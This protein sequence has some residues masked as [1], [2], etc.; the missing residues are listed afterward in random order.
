MGQPRPERG[1]SVRRSTAG[2]SRR[3]AILPVPLRRENGQ[4]ISPAR[5][6]RSNTPPAD[7]RGAPENAARR[8]RP[9]SHQECVG[10]ARPNGRRFG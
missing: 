1:V 3:V 7:R 5:H 8:E 9:Q 10:Q 2:L 4:E 6:P